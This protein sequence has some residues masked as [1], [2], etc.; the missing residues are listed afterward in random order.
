MP[1]SLDPSSTWSPWKW[2]QLAQVCR[3][4][5]FLVFASPHR[6]DLRVVYTFKRKARV[7]KKA[8]GRWPTLPIA[9]WY[10]SQCTIHEDENNASVALQH[11]NRIREISLFLTDSLLYKTRAQ[12]LASFPALEYL[13]LESL[14]STESESPT[15]PVRFLGSSAPRLSHIHLNGVTFP[16]LPQLLLSTRDLVSLQLESISESGYFSPETLSISLSMM[17]QLKSLI[18][19]FL[20]LASSEMESPGWPL[21]VRAILPALTKFRFSGDRD[22]LSDLITMLDSPV[23]ER[24]LNPRAFETQRLLHFITR[25]R[26]KVI[27]HQYFL[28]LEDKIFSIKHSST[29]SLP[30]NHAILHIVSQEINSKATLQEIDSK[31]THPQALP[32][33]FARHSMN[34][35]AV[36]RIAMKSFLPRSHWLDHD[37]VDLAM[38]VVFLGLLASATVLEVAGVFVQIIGSVLERFPC[39]LVQTMLPALK[40]LHVGTCETLR[41]FENFARARR[42][43]GR[44]ITVHYAVPS[45]GGN[46]LA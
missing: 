25:P 30:M 1:N 13:R 2:H 33:I 19:R 41:P 18:I 35:H 5:R 38:W 4:W 9:V 23:L 31:P 16:T 37:D 6:L 26:L 8:L 21:A 15:L 42:A 28:L 27:T 39:G 22:Y 14:N 20:S 32:Y 11:P 17:T 44:P 46:S 45:N 10:P 7:M 43:E 40:D 29:P 34:I 12:L 24:S 3:R 36:Q